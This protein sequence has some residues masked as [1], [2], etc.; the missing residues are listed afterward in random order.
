MT[1]LRVFRQPEKAMRHRLDIGPKMS[2]R[3]VSGCAILASM[4]RAYANWFSYRF[5]GFSPK[6]RVALA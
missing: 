4:F 2:L 3:R 1:V 5:W 6:G